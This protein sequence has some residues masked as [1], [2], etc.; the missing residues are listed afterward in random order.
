M[1]S[2]VFAIVSMLVAGLAAPAESNAQAAPGSVFVTVY[3]DNLGVVREIRT[4]DIPRGISE[5]RVADVASLINPATV[6]I[7]FNGS[8]LEQNYQYD[9]VSADKILQR[10]ID[11]EVQ[12]IDEKGTIIR[13]TLLSTQGGSAVIRSA[14]GGLM[15]LPGLGK[16]QIT[17]DELPGGLITRPTL[18]WKVQTDRAGSQNVEMTYQ[19][20]G[21]SWQAEYVA[22]LKDNDTKLDLNAWVNLTNNSGATFRNAN[23]KLVAGSVN[24]VR[25]PSRSYV[26]EEGFAVMAKTADSQFESGGL[27]EYHMYTLQRPTDLLQNESK[28]IALFDAAGIPVVK[29]YRYLG[30]GQRGQGVSEPVS[31][32][33]EFK[34]ESANGLGIPMPMGIVRVNQSSGGSV[35]FVGEDR[36]NHTP[37]DEKIT[38]TLGQAFDLL[39][40]TTMTDQ[41]R[42]TDRVNEMSY[43]VVLKNR[44]DTAVTIEVERNLWGNWEVMRSSRE[45][46]KVNANKIAF[47]VPVPANSEVEITYTV[48]ITN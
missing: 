3:N 48:R 31:V 41:R 37:R 2:T 42:I 13:G 14:N 5:I 16:Y 29:R 10:F 35:E 38:L 47:D 34:N 43:K 24:R 4:F 32:Q 21:M 33:V 44:K 17:V 22:V 8:V 30:E 15:M 9:L 36:I 11:R 46:R 12:F 23:L 18:L 20:G 40:E 6:K 39:G 27:F 28:Q 45:Y 1:K 26:Y 19:T 25:P 7:T